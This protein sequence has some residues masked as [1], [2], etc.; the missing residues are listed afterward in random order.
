MFPS[1]FVSDRAGSSH[2][3][4]EPH[5]CCQEHVPCFNI[6][7]NAN[8]EI[9]TFSAVSTWGVSPDEAGGPPP[10]MPPRPIM[11]GMFIVAET[12]TRRREG[13]PRSVHCPDLGGEKTLWVG[14]KDGAQKQDSSPLALSLKRSETPSS[15]HNRAPT[16]RCLAAPASACLS[17]IWVPPLERCGRLVPRLPCPADE[18][19]RHASIS[20]LVTFVSQISTRR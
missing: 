3:V 1:F 14:K 18:E 15:W 19:S 17:Q 13:A 12:P 10:I 16:S 6:L 5:T 11:P 4:L 7:S 9:W 20:F 8:E 2:A